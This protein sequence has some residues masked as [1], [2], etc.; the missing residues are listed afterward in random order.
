VSETLEEHEHAT[1]A[2]EGGRR[3]SALLIA[4]LAAG[5]AFSEQG[6]QHAQTAM[7][8]SA[9]AATD[10]WGQY[11]AKSIRANEAKD[12]ALVIQAAAP[13][14]AER[15][16]AVA[17]LNGDSNRFET[18][19]KTGKASIAESAKRKEEERDAAHE[20]LEAYDNAAAALQLAIVITTASVIT[21]SRALAAAGL[22]IGLIGAVLGVLGLLNPTLAAW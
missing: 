21:R 9:I 3:Y 14:S 10:L 13:A 18:D 17:K 15:D 11:Q 19:P 22:I 4:A 12:L 6:A 7:S 8:N 1:E 5:L 20:H 2:A 16:A